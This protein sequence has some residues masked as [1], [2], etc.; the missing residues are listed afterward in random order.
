MLKYVLLGALAYQPLT[1]YQLK[2]F[3]D[4]SAKHFWYAQTSQ[5]YR[6]LNKLQAEALL[7]S[8]I[9]EQEERPDRRLYRMTDAGRADLL[10]WL[11]QPMTEVEPTKDTLLVRLFFSARLDK[12]VV[13]TQLRLQLALRQQQLHLFRTEIVNQIKAGLER[14]PEL[15]RD[16]L[17]WDAARRLGE[18]GEE[19]YIRWLEETIQRIETDF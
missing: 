5:I 3:V 19:A 16:A 18:L 7:T 4:R 13:L 17:L 10:A 1:G 6:E 11:T 9:Q 8:E 15:K 14:Q 2:Q 12:A